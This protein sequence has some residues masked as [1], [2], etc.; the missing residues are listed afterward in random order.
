MH[1]MH[2]QL[3]GPANLPIMLYNYPGR[4]GSM[5]GEEYLDRVGQ[6]I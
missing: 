6:V 1:F 4:M 3:I 5:M 2:S